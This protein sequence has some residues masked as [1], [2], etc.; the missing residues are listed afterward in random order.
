[1][2]ARRPIKKIEIVV[3]N[4]T[5]CIKNTLRGREN[6]TTELCVDAISGLEWTIVLRA[7]IDGLG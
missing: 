6:T 4:K 1:L 2:V 7:E 3:V 5:R